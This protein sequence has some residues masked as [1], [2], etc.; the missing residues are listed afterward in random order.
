M[1]EFSLDFHDTATAYADK[2]DAELKEK[3]RLFRMLNSPFLNSVRHGNDEVR[4]ILGLPVE[5][6]IKGDDLQAVLRR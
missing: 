2:S 1:S 5:R 3:Y 4:P 6:M